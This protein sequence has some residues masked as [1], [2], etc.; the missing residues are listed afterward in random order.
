[1]SISRNSGKVKEAAGEK[2]IVCLRSGDF[3]APRLVKS[4]SS[5]AQAGIRKTITRH[6]AGVE[7]KHSEHAKK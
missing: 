7:H 4:A 1:M 3:N 2:Q 6:V 5:L